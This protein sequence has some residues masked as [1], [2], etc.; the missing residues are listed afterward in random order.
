MDFR[1]SKVPAD[2][3]PASC[4]VVAIY[5]S[6]RLSPAAQA[7]NDASHGELMRLVR[8]FEMQGSTG[9]TLTLNSLPNI[10]AQQARSLCFRATDRKATFLTQAA[11]RTVYR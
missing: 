4:I 9:D 1:V 3:Q 10:K 7:I 5:E 11:T 2:K 6:R 8:R